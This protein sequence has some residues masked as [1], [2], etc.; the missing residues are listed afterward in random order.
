MCEW[1]DRTPHLKCWNANCNSFHSSRDIIYCFCWFSTL[2]IILIF[3]ITIADLIFDHLRHRQSTTGRQ[4]QVQL[5]LQCAKLPTRRL[6]TQNQNAIFNYIIVGFNLI[7]RPNRNKN[8]T[9]LSILFF[10]RWIHIRCACSTMVALGE[11]YNN[12][13]CTLISQTMHNL[14]VMH[15]YP[16]ANQVFLGAIIVSSTQK[17]YIW[18]NVMP[19]LSWHR[20]KRRNANM[21]T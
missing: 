10:I 13:S 3:T 21:S 15:G 2:A 9:I 4:T 18:M 7:Y 6:Q 14:C 1:R 17:L 5:P 20:L 8:Y 16:N 12:S 19:I 11:W